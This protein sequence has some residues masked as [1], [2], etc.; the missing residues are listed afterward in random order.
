MAD[1]D[2]VDMLEGRRLITPTEAAELRQEGEEL[3][4]IVEKRVAPMKQVGGFVC[5]KCGDSH[6]TCCNCAMHN[7]HRLSATVKRY[8]A[9]L[10]EVGCVY[11]S[12]GLEHCADVGPSPEPPRPLCVVCAALEGRD[13]T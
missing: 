13:G 9:A 4:R 10:R 8:E 2:P 5:R 3:R 11:Q 6:V 7:I 12:G 1:F